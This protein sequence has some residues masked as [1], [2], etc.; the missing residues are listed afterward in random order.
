MAVEI[1]RKFLVKADFVPDSDSQIEIIQVYLCADP[2]R[3]VRVR[4]GGDNAF[5]TIK[6]KP[7]GISRAEFEYE[8]PVEDARQMIGLAVW[9]AIEKVRHLIDFDGKKWEV[10]VFSGANAGLIIAEIELSNADE[11][12]RLP[13]WVAE[14]VSEDRRFHNSCLAQ[15]PYCEWKNDR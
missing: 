6:S 3:T 2:E 15:N 5:L 7:K 14:E 9:P 12:V 1:E 4:I 13:D 10:D 11:V 8:I